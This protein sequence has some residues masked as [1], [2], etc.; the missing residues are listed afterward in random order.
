[1]L[2]VVSQ[3]LEEITNLERKRPTQVDLINPYNEYFHLALVL[4]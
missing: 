3:Q 2:A 1:M 4:V